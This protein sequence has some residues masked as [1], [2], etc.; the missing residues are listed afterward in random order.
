MTGAHPDFCIFFAATIRDI[1]GYVKREGLALKERFLLRFLEVAE[2]LQDDGRFLCRKEDLHP[3]L[4]DVQ[5]T[6][7]FD[8]HYIYHTAW[9]ARVLAR[10]RP[11][12]HIDISSSLYFVSIASAFVPITFYDYRPAPLTLGNLR[13]KRA[14]LTSLPFADE[15][16]DSL[17]CMHVVEHI[18]LERYGDPFSPQGDIAAMRELARVLGRGGRLLFAVPIGGVA[19]IHYNAHRIY[20]Y[21]AVLEAFG[22]LCLEEFALVTD[23]GEF[24]AHAS[25]AEAQQQKYGCGCFLF[26]K[27]K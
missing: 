5:G 27:Q 22:S 13:C 15:S 3:C 12:S 2:Q 8:A 14:D 11:A 10:T 18:G 7:P 17:S 24:I 4:N 9:A 6:T 20:T 26:R 21:S 23:R 16:V 19:K 1:G 25:E